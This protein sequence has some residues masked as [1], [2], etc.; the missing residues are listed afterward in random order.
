MS[1]PTPPDRIASARGAGGGARV[2]SETTILV[3]PDFEE[4]LVD[5]DTGEILTFSAASL[6]GS[7]LIAV[8]GGLRTASA[9][10]LE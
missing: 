5:P 4:T 1:D 2:P 6:F 10:G 3:D 9:E 8:A 7:R